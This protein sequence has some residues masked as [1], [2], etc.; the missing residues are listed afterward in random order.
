ME[1][2]VIS[3]VSTMYHSADYVE[4]F[5]L[6][7]RS[8]L[9]DLDV[10]CYEFI[11]VDDGSPDNSLELAVNLVKSDSRVTVV[12]LSRNFGHNKA[13]ATGLSYARGDYVFLI[14]MDLEEPPELLNEF[15]LKLQAE[16]SHVDVVYGVQSARKGNGLERLTG[17]CYYNVFNWLSD[18]F[19]I[20]PNISTV[21][22]MKQG[23]VKSILRF[24]EEDYYFGAASIVAGFNQVALHFD[25]KSHSKTTYDFFKKY[26]LFF[27]SVFSFSKKPLYMI[28]YSG[29]MLT[30]GAFFFG[31]SLIFRKLFFDA[32][33]S[34]W[35]SI[36]VSIWFLGG[37]IILFLGVMAIYLAKIFSQ[38]K[39][40]PFSIVKKEYR[41]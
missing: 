41:Q 5:Y 36:M 10:D 31:A 37:I 28:F 22:L 20:E 29:L 14:D 17:R 38:T 26:R 27:E 24:N 3:I 21:R 39:N 8:V 16:K 34:G 6:R 23:F 32:T 1:N 15:W 35:T 18:D 7:C 33:L 4:L 9:A 2:P 25:K 30:M 40:H 12:E 13:I 19:K 11:L